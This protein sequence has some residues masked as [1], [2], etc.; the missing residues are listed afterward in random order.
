MSEG[1]SE[2]NMKYKCLD[3]GVISCLKYGQM[4]QTPA[5]SEILGESWSLVSQVK[6][7]KGCLPT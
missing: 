5:S 2:R 1:T 4:A 6:W 3:I 7:V